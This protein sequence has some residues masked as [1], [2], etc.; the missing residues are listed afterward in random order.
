MKIEFRKI[1]LDGAE[2]KVSLDSVDFLGTFSKISS[3]L[4][5]I[6]GVISGNLE[7]DCCKC[8]KVINERLN[9]KSIF[10]VNDGIF[11]S[12]NDVKEEFVIIEIEDHILDFDDILHGEIE[13]LKSEYYTC[14]TCKNND[15]YVEL[16]Y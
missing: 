14:D 12:N 10:I 3:K 1:P 4:A 16:Q 2:F 13:S 8:G 7:V 9:E 15:T 11:T 6:D 5:K